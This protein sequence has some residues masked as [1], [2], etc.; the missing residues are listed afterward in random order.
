MT[1]TK[2]SSFICCVLLLMINL[3][4]AQQCGTCKEIP[5]IAGFGFDIKVAA[6]NKEA[7]TENL[8]PEW[9]KLFTFAS[10]V[11][12]QIG[13]NEKGCIQMMTPPSVDTGDVEWM[14]VGGETFVNLPSNP[15]ISPNLSKYGDYLLTGSITNNGTSCQ[16]QVEVQTACSRKTVVTGQI[17]FSLLSVSGN[18]SNIAHQVVIQLSPLA[19]KIKKFELTERQQARE[20]SLFPVS[21]ADPIK[22]TPQKKIVKAG[23]TTAFTIE[24]KDC[25][26][27]PLAGREV[28]FNE[29]TFEG[30]K[31]PGAIGG[32][33]T[34]AKVVTDA[35]GIAKATFTLK[36]GS[37][38]AFIAAHSP[39]KDVK[40]C[41]SILFGDAPVNMKY[42]YSGYVVYTYEGVSQLTTDTDDKVMNNF[43]TGKETTSI[44]Y[45]ASFYGEGTATD[46]TLNMSDEEI[47]T[48][49]PDVLG[50]GSYK[51]NK[52]DYWKFTIICNCAGKGDV[53]EQKT[54]QASGG[55]IKNS[56]VNFSCNDNAGKIHL[57]MTFTTTGSNSYQ[58]T[59]MPSQ[60]STSQDDLYWPVDFDTIT[61]KNFTIK[62]E[63]VGNRTRYTAQ[64]EN[65]IKLSNGSQTA[66]I[67]MV[68]WE[69]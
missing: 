8:W 1:A 31:I 53:T 40:G 3:A 5:R 23:E 9:K 35:N 17:N 61:D 66:K 50:S 10:V 20:L 55:G 36:A 59:H 30:F 49:V 45:R 52:S 2:P 38:E 29:T 18:V 60:S 51:Y 62:K 24:V 41:N 65:T 58:A 44:S 43:Y 26:G 16:L 47:G 39:G 63:T 21:W 56:N 69:E 27:I 22:I 7:G 33:V 19:D 46:I 13:D 54:R 42:T 32:T 57:D 34:P 4:K 64:G 25:D 14:S 68:V 37:K 67:K 28:L 15:L 12:S 11:A 48:G 6:P